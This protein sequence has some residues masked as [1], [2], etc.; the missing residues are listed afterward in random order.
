[1]DGKLRHPADGKAWKSFDQLYPE[2]AV[3]SRNVE[4][5]PFGDKD[6]GKSKPDNSKKQGEKRKKSTP[7]TKPEVSNHVLWK[8]KRKTK[9]NYDARKDLQE[10]GLRR[11]LHPFTK[12]G[13]NYMP[14]ACHTMSNEDKISFLKVLRDVRVPDGYASNISRCVRLKDCTITGLKS[15]DNHILMQQ[16]LPIALRGSLPGNV[17]RP[18]VEMGTFFRGICSTTLTLDNLYQLQSEV[19]VT[20]CKME[21]RSLGGFKSNVRNKVALE[22]C[23][24]EG[25]IAIEL[26]TFCSMYLD[27]AST[28]HNKAQRNPDGCKGAGTRVI[29]NRITL[30]QIHRYILFN[31]DEFLPLRIGRTAENQLESHH[32]ELFVDWYREY[33]NGLDDLRR[34]ELGEK[35]VMHCRGPKET[36]V[37]YNRYV[38]NEK[39]FCT[40]TKYVLLKCDWADN[41]RDRGY[42]VDEY[43]ITLV[44]FKNLIR[45]GESITDVPFVLTSQVDQVFYVENERN[46][47]WACA[48]RTKP[49]NVYDVGQGQRSD[50]SSNNYHEIEPLLLS[51]NHDHVN[52]PDDVDYVR[53]DLE[54]IEA[55]V[56]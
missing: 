32:F 23:I 42:K 38:V 19:C 27:D 28:F 22:G 34:Q 8:K 4:G 1:M 26:E 5:M 15:H 43:G 37:K 7:N 51:S 40:L 14:P 31:S 18:L 6:G 24:A 52:A 54:P 25:Y 29:L 3:D 48:V 33:V 41:T 36:A 2:F 17:V 30:A 10:M 55:Y 44:N 12:N 21:Q 53:P 49:R 16:L 35:L 39:L 56:I 46:P 45:T 11:L 20:L 9:D 50:E 47:Y 13:K